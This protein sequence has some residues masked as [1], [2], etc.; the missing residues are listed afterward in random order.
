MRARS[1]I[2]ALLLSGTALSMPALA[3]PQLLATATLTQATDLSGLTSTLENGDAQNILGGIGS[4]LAYAGGGTFLAAPDRGPNAVPYNSHVDDT[5]SYIERFQTVQMSLSATPGGSLPYSLTP[6]LTGTTLLYSATPLNYGGNPGGTQI[7]GAPMPAGD[8]VNGSSGK[9]YFTGRSD[10]F[11]SDVWHR[12]R[13]AQPAERAA[14]RR[15]H[16]RVAGGQLRV[17]FG[18]VWTVCV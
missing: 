17:R 1:F 18:R 16:A 11:G 4:A 6:T 3:A 14:R 7:N 2:P 5:A 10:S 13:V 8:A 15:G 12:H 9:Y